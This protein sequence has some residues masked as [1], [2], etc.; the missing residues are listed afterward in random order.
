MSF[1]HAHHND[2][3]EHNDI[4]VALVGQPNSGKSSV[5][6]YLTGRHQN[7]A[8]Y[9]G[10]TVTK[11]SGHYH[12]GSRRIEVVDLP[13]TYSLTSYSQEERVTRDFL[14]LERPEAVVLVIDAANLRRH[15][16][17]AFQ[18]RELQMPL[19]VCLNMMDTA[20]RRGIQIDFHQLEQLLGVPVVPTIARLGFLGTPQCP[21]G[22]QCGGNCSLRHHDTGLDTLRKK[23][24]EI[25]KRHD[26][27]PPA[28]WRIDYGGL[29]PL[30]NEIDQ[31]LAEHPP[32]VQDFPTRWL[33]IKL[34]ENDREAR[35]IIQ[36]HLH[37]E[38][39]EALLD[40]CIKKVEIYSKSA[41]D[42][43]RKTIAAVRNRQAEITEQ[44]VVNRMSKPRRNSDLLDRIFCHP[45]FGL[46]SVAL[47]MFLM[48]KAAFNLADGFTWF[49]WLSEAGGFEWNT[50]L[51]AVESVFSVWLPFLF[52]RCFALPDNWLHSL[53]YDGILA[54][55]GGVLT[56]V[57]TIFFIFLFMSFL[58]QSG[59]IARIVVVLDKIMRFF[60]LH[61]QSI[62]PMILGGGIIGGCALPA[63][64]ATR[65]MREQRERILTILVIPLM[66]CGAKVPVFV[67]LISA[68][69]Q[70]YE[71]WMLAAV[72][73]ISWAAAILAAS[74]LGKFFIKGEPSPLVIELPA[75]Q[76][77]TLRDVLFTSGLQSWWFIKKAGT[78]I[79]AVNVLLWALMYF[80]S[81]GEENS[82]QNSYAAKLGKGLEPVSLYAGF[83]WRDNVA[84]IGGFAAKEV[85]VSTMG[86]LYG[87]E[88]AED[89]T[90]EGESAEESEAD[91]TKN[92]VSALQA[93][94]VWSPL[95]AFGFLLFI[96][97]YNPCI[98]TCAVIW[99][100]TGYIK[101]MLI[102]M[103]YTNVLAAVAAV[104]VYQT[105]RMFG[106]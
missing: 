4:L 93:E 9:P 18:L 27:E 106:L 67:L 64:M 38:G 53:I 70:Q 68:F 89:E 78:I 92:L 91:Q 90:I 43:P 54:G 73:L 15:L 13:G 61:G 62:L 69:F 94:K 59:Y 56:F 50:P 58:E 63:V 98:A 75:Y 80:P 82:L 19:L 30:I 25:S 77:P 103:F 74:I 12:D 14:L 6:N 32:I 55:I 11:K 87:L 28:D 85:I 66:N 1:T 99:R 86:T 88:S 21:T 57:P 79:L 84:L 101:Y 104:A 16:Y 48:F 39:W 34:L 42:S 105:G 71:E 41:E 37:S 72:I 31:T 44:T 51:G 29:E 46:V 102:A 97:F 96:M 52:D 81:G 26:H 33:A 76:M 60:G 2:H 8:N 17:F 23:I 45:V 22:C 5:F 7:V 47:I 49:P 20:Q 10:V 95:K 24:N 100:E 36:H 40:S 83:D 65:S 35:R 3:H